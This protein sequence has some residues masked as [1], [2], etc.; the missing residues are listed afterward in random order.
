MH[1]RFENWKHPEDLFTAR[2]REDAEDT[3]DFSQRE[4]VELI[5]HSLGMDG[6][7]TDL[8]LEIWSILTNFKYI[9][10]VA[11]VKDYQR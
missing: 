9:I 2:E 11:S 6:S 10:Y 3:E 4:S 8:Y 7:M 5:L 1:L